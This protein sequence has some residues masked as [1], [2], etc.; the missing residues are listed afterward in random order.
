MHLPVETVEEILNHLPPYDKKSLRNCSLIT[1]SWLDPC[2]RRLFERVRISS[3]TCQ[4]WLDN[5]SP[6]NTVLLSHV[7]ELVYFAEGE[8]D[9]QD[10]PTERVDDGLSIYLPSF[11]QLQRLT[12]DYVDIE[13]TIPHNPTLFFAF[14]HSLS[15]LTLL[16]VSIT[17][18]GF[19]TLLG[20]FP[21]LRNL[22]IREM[23]FKEGI[24][25]TPRPPCALR[26]RLLV[27]CTVESTSYTDRFAGL[28]PEYEELVLMGEY[29]QDLVTAVEDNLKFLRITKCVCTSPSYIHCFAGYVDNLTSQRTPA[30]I[31]RAAPNFN[32]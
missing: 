20:Y 28:D 29:D 26:G 24:R 5:I 23:Q 7:R 2:Q 10:F 12:F 1:K 8:R 6:N 31:S 9:P 15:S 21:N 19:V 22:E 30:P 4:S 18:G 27:H 3:E 32:S 25:P 13:P 17:W 11:C 16:Q 14:Q